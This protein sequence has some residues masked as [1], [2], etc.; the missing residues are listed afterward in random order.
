[1]SDAECRDL[2]KV[3]L[4][5]MEIDKFAEDTP[6]GETKYA[7]CHSMMTASSVASPITCKYRK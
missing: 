6:V 5:I 1:L 4:T 3:T 2:E 7:E